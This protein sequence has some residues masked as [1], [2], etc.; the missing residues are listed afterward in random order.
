MSK[1]KLL[2]LSGLIA[3]SISAMDTPEIGDGFDEDSKSAPASF[4]IKDLRSPS[5]DHISQ[6]V[7]TSPTADA[8][9]LLVAASPCT[10]LDSELFLQF[11]DKLSLSN[12][13]NATPLQKNIIS[14]Q[15]KARAELNHIYSL[16]SE[17]D[18]SGTGEAVRAIH[19]KRVIKLQNTLL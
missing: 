18:E 3:G 12:L 19:E 17:A 6:L 2:V 4:D 16:I 10:D 5:V 14:A 11:K 8:A 7:E 13:G 1:I 15:L 9:R